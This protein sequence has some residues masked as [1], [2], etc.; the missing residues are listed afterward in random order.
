MTIAQ[1]HRVVLKVLDHSSPDALKTDLEQHRDGVLQY[2]SFDPVHN[3]KNSMRWRFVRAEL[4]VA[5]SIRIV[6]R[7]I[8]SHDVDDS[9]GNV[10]I[11]F[12]LHDGRLWPY[13]CDGDAV[14]SRRVVL[15]G[16]LTVQRANRRRDRGLADIFG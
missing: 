12:H 4:F 13:N 15:T 2:E 14:L 9:F 8:D 11:D 3:A 16:L 1:W 7:G 6:D 10:A 5:G